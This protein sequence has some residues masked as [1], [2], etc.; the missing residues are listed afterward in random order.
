MEDLVPAREHEC[1]HEV[2]DRR[3][4]RLLPFHDVQE[5]QVVLEEAVDFPQ[6]GPFKAE[7]IED[8]SKEPV[9]IEGKT[10]SGRGTRFYVFSYDPSKSGRVQETEKGIDFSLLRWVDV[11]I[12]A[13]SLL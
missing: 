5:S 10:T 2:A 3:E 9:G 7:G 13:Q 4:S 11:K 1:V 12:G 8:G 6:G